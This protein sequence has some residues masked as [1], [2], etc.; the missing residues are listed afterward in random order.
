MR[1]PFAVSV[2]VPYTDVW[3]FAPVAYY[4]GKHPCE[5]PQDLMRHT[6]QSS[7]REG[8]VVADFFMGSGATGKAAVSLGRQFIGVEL[9]LPRFELTCGEIQDVL[10]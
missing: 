4:P 3:Q 5:K 1:R 6:I 9:E 10:D 7:S 2:D 8:Q